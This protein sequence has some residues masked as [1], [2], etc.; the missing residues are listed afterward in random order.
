M[1]QL[2]LKL[3]ASW[4]DWH[5]IVGD[6]SLLMVTQPHVWHQ[7]RHVIF[8]YG[9]LRQI[10]KTISLTEESIEGLWSDCETFPFFESILHV[11]YQLRTQYHTFYAFSLYTCLAPNLIWGFYIIFSTYHRTLS[12]PTIW[13]GGDIV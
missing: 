6:E 10:C 8:S 11:E 2:V 3:H 4:H 7:L 1:L 5:A 9:L 13:V 12:M